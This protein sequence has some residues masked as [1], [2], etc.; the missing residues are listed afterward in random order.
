MAEML[1]T[2]DNADSTF[3]DSFF[4]SRVFDDLNKILRKVYEVLSDDT[5]EYQFSHDE[6][7]LW[8]MSYIDILLNELR[9]LGFQVEYVDETFC[10]GFRFH[11][12]SKQVFSSETQV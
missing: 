11:N 5:P 7:N 4:K 12:T 8:E 2:L 6:E 1:E 3:A 10:T 9:R